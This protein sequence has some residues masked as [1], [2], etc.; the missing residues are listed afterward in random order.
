M[1]CVVSRE[2][3]CNARQADLSEWLLENHPEDVIREG[4]RS[5]RL[6]T[7]PSVNIGI[8]FS[9]YKDFS[10]GESGNTIPYSEGVYVTSHGDVDYDPTATNPHYHNDEDG[11]DWDFDSWLLDLFDGDP[12][13]V[14]F[15]WQIVARLIRP[16]RPATGIVLFTAT[17]GNNGK[18]T[19]VALFREL[20]GKQAWTS[21]P[22]A[23]FA[24]RFGLKDLINAQVVLTDENRMEFNFDGADRLKAAADGS[25]FK[26]EIRYKGYV[27]MRFPGLMIQCVNELPR[28]KDKTGSWY[29]RLAVVPFTKS[30]TGHERKYIKSDYLKRPEVLAYV[31]KRAIETE[32]EDIDL[33]DLMPDKCKAALEDY[34]L[35]N[36]PVRQYWEEISS[37]LVWNRIPGTFLYDLYCAW[38]RRNNPSGNAVSKIVFNRQLAEIIKDDPIWINKMGKNDTIRKDKS[39]D[40][41][42]HLIIEYDL[43]NWMNRTYQGFNTTQRLKGNVPERFRGLV[44]ATD[45]DLNGVI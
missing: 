5:L 8:G 21:V 15:F 41:P 9:G 38:N 25:A 29:R 33:H 24:E 34:K 42:E 27:N 43:R 39:N 2:Q 44:R 19:L 10:T 32:V 11:T 28:I 37:Q 13:M 36:D 17:T 22:L 14:E 23:E 20:V 4:R 12:E 35:T 7:D 45:N 40:L 31:K 16:F 3:I 6:V 1:N 26:V 30:F 18:G